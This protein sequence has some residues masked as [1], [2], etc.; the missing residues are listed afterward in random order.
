M[1]H[2]FCPQCGSLDSKRL[3]SGMEECLRCKFKGDFKEGSM[4]EINAFRK[5]KRPAPEPAASSSA[6]EPK[7]TFR[8]QLGTSNKELKEKLKSLKGK[9][10]GDYEI[11]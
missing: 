7:Q 1:K 9:S 4:D 3:V 5:S 2:K 6:G 8:P 10:T 11:S